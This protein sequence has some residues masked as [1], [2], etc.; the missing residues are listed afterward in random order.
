MTYTSEKWQCISP[1]AAMRSFGT[2]QHRCCLQST[3]LPWPYTLPLIL[4]GNCCCM[5]CEIRMEAEGLRWHFGFYCLTDPFFPFHCQILHHCLFLSSPFTALNFLF[6][7]AH[8]NSL[9]GQWRSLSD[10]QSWCPFGLF[11][12]S[13]GICI[14]IR[15]FLALPWAVQHKKLFLFVITRFKKENKFQ[16]KNEC[17]TISHTY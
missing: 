2:L 17:L 7:P 14:N 9:S 8:S 10:R 11:C 16:V 1:A 3:W 4:R 13:K 6:F 5:I 12:C 15:P